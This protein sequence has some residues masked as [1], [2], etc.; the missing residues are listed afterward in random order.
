MAFNE[1]RLSLAYAIRELQDAQNALPR[2]IDR[3][4]ENDLFEMKRRLVL[5]REYA[6]LIEAFIERRKLKEAA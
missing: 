5:I 4:D 2:N 3:Y 6:D 1:A